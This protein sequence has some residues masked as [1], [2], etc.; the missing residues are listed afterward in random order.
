MFRFLYAIVLSTDADFKLKKKAPR[1]P[2]V[3]IPLADGL[4][5]TVPTAEYNE[6]VRRRIDE[7]EVFR[8]ITASGL[9]RLV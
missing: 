4:A 1:V 8:S 5:Y 7:P 6:F 9:R 3:E 2:M